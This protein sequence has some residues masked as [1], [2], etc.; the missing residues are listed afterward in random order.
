MMEINNL[1]GNAYDASYDALLE[2]TKNT[3][4]KSILYIENA[5]TE[6]YFAVNLDISENS[7]FK[8]PKELEPL[9]RNFDKYD[10]KYIYRRDILSSLVR[11]ITNACIMTM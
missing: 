9:I 6:V 8:M 7:N 4:T 10:L 2:R 1:I 3:F 5:L 11:I